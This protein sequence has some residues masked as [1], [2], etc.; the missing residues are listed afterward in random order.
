MATPAAE[1]KAVALQM[2]VGLAGVR[3]R[4]LQQ[5]QQAERMR[6][7]AALMRTHCGSV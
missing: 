7:K 5:R 3:E 4:A 6:E 1:S 2:R